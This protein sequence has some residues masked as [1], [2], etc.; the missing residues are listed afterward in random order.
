MQRMRLTVASLLT[1]VVAA[2]LAG[3]ADAR[4]ARR[5]GSVTLPRCV[6][7]AGWCGSARRPLDPAR[8]HGP[9]V[10]IR[11]VWLPAGSRSAR[12]L[13]IVAGEGGAGFAMVESTWG[14]T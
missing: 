6:L 5:V 14:Y 4:P 12:G 10:D 13:A 11:L 2:A 3:P 7:M 8:P 9:S 1:I